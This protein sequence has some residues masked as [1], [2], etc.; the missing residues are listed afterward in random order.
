[1][2]G[3]HSELHKNIPAT[4]E[5]Q[6][7]QEQGRNNESLLL[8]D[9]KPL[10]QWDFSAFI[11]RFFDGIPFWS[12][13]FLHFLLLGGAT[14]VVS[15]TTVTLTYS[16]VTGN[17]AQSGSLTWTSAGTTNWATAGEDFTGSY[18]AF[19]G[20]ASDADVTAHAEDVQRLVSEWVNSTVLNQGTAV[21]P[22]QTLGSNYFQ[23][24]SDEATDAANRPQLIVTYRTNLH[25]SVTCGDTGAIDL[26]FSG[27]ISLYDYACTTADGSGLK[28][29][30]EDQLSLTEGTSTVVVTA[31]NGSTSNTS[32]I[33]T[34]SKPYLWCR[35]LSSSVPNFYKV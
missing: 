33:L 18:G 22:P 30:S 21:V 16:K 26:T 32:V 14:P 10:Y 6:T 35:G 5:R 24:H 27:G 34:A 29:T 8:A 17:A 1:M 28:P 25:T 2:Y 7:C 13:L 19:T 4:Q 9:S 23:I 11:L 20:G 3:T 15:Q 12:S 31:A